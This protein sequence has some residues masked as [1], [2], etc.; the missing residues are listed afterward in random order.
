MESQEEAGDCGEFYICMS[1]RIS[2][3]GLT[4]MSLLPIKYWSCWVSNL[5]SIQETLKG[6]FQSCFPN[7]NTRH[8]LMD[9][10]FTIGPL[11]NVLYVC[12]HQVTSKYLHSLH[13]E[14]VR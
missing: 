4:V 12:E 6:P 3:P 2:Y 8:S 10:L 7:T 1:Y 13:L 11:Q 14:G 5:L 9:R